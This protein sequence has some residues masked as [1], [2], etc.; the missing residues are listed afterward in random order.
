M[1]KLFSLQRAV[2]LTTL[3]GASAAFAIGAPRPCNLPGTSSPVSS[4]SCY[5]SSF[6][7]G[8]YTWTCSD[9]S[10]VGR[11]PVADCSTSCYSGG[12]APPAPEQTQQ[13][14]DASP[15]PETQGCSSAAGLGGAALALI[16]AA[17]R[18]RKAR[19]A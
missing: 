10:W 17:L 9:G 1:L 15:E 11:T 12:L 6:N 5:C 2:V 4:G 3:V 18:R 16:A 14:L 13:R 7:T 8:T 19:G